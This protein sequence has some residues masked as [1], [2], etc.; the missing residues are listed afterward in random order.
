MRHC[1]LALLVLFPAA[2]AAAESPWR[3]GA[4]LG[5][6]ERTN[7][8]VFADDVP[9]VV[10]LDI[11]WFG[12]RFFFDNGDVGFTFADNALVTASL[13]ARVK[14]DRVFFGRTNTR[15]VT[16]SL[17]GAPLGVATR[18]EVPDRDYAIEAG[19][20]LLS[21]GRWGYLQ[22]A[23]FHDVSGTHDG[24]DVDANYGIGFARGKW[25]FE[26]SVGLTYKS[27]ALN[28]Y[29]WGIR[30]SE[31]NDATPVYTAS[32]GVNTRARLRASYY[33]SRNWSATLSAEYE[34][35]ND[36]VADSPI[37]DDDAVFGWFAGVAWR[38]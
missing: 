37:V 20:E 8:I 23:A 27:S 6:G 31:S 22:L 24:F 2:A 21:D 26:P 10:D 12:E 13:M 1:L 4:A 25:Y 29:Y 11:A 35:I 16:V 14:S 34:R 18:V 9:I 38:F 33:F 30:P 19:I 7:P 28:D 3:L 32:D 15:F 5:Y 36:S 17:T